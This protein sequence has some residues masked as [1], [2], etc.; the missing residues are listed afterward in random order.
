MHQGQLKAVTRKRDQG[1]DDDKK[2]R[3]VSINQK[4]KLAEMS[5]KKKKSK[6]DYKFTPIV[7]SRVSQ[8]NHYFIMRLA[9][10]MNQCLHVDISEK[11]KMNEEGEPSDE[12]EDQGGLGSMFQK[13]DKKKT[14][15][16]D[17]E[18][19]IPHKIQQIKYHLVVGQMDTFLYEHEKLF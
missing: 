7:L 11:R 10:N 2:E 17:E 18:E 4:F 3:N 5:Q 1:E 19:V 16:D 15:G 9:R 14:T 8:D 13:K 6:E 12:E